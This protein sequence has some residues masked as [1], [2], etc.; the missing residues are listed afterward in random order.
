MKVCSR[1]VEGGDGAEKVSQAVLTFGAELI[2]ICHYAM[3]DLF[4]NF[5]VFFG[6]EEDCVTALREYIDKELSKSE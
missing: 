6:V 1:I 3:G 2:N 4:P 5:I